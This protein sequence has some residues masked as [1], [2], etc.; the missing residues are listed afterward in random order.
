MESEK[1]TA[2]F[3]AEQI[4][5]TDFEKLMVYKGN[6]L[7]RWEDVLGVWNGNAIKW[8]VMITGQL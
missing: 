5:T 3:F 6:R 7:R 2:N 8:V 4:L 1:R